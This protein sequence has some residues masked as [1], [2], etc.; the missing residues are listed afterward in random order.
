VVFHFLGSGTGSHCHEAGT[1]DGGSHALPDSEF[2]PDAHAVTLPDDRGQAVDDAA[3]NHC[4]HFDRAVAWG[5]PLEEGEMVNNDRNS[6]SAL[7]ARQRAI[8]ARM[9]QT[10]ESYVVRRAAMTSKSAVR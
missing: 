8:R 2:G 4:D 9:E 1:I 10:G 3:W 5:T 6:S 7:R